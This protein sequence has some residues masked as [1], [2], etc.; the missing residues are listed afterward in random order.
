MTGHED[1][2]WNDQQVAAMSQYLKN[3]G[4]LFADACCG[5]QKFDYAFKREIAKVLGGQGSGGPQPLPLNHPAY[6]IQHKIAKVQYTE[7]ADAR[8]GGKMGDA[9]KLEGATVGNR[10]A[11]IYSPVSLNV[12][13][14]LHPVP[15]SVAYAPKS[16][17]DLGVNVVMYAM[18]Q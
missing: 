14:R 5:R 16:A 7:A 4:F 8:A 11:V 15:Y 9:P 17:L 12:G 6:T 2:T 13:W 1:F 18:G 10:V 3:G